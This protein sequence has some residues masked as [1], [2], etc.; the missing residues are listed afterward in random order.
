MCQKMNHFFGIPPPLSP[1]PRD[2][3]K[4]N[5]WFFAS[6]SQI[7]NIFGW[8]APQTVKSAYAFKVAICIC[9]YVVNICK[10]LK[11]NTCCRKK[12]DSALWDT[13]NDIFALWADSAFS[14]GLLL[15]PHPSFIWVVRYRWSPERGQ[16][17]DTDRLVGQLSELAL[18][19]YISLTPCRYAKKLGLNTRG[20][21][22]AAAL[23]ILILFLI[24][25]IIAMA[26]CWPGKHLANIDSKIQFQVTGPQCWFVQIACKL[27]AHFLHETC[28]I[29]SAPKKRHRSQLLSPLPSTDYH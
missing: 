3:V 25:V 17:N 12:N 18:K 7:T 22:V 23:A 4:R 21:Y 5:W 8:S 1:P 2:P 15:A 14:C 24:I 6:V 26:A 19:I 29:H 27:S 11:Y 9:N 13:W 16:C 20:C 28:H 10:A